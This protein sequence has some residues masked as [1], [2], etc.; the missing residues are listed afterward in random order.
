MDIEYSTLCKVIEVGGFDALAQARITDAFFMDEENLRVFQ[1]AHQH[2]DRHGVSPGHEAFDHEF[3]HLSLIETPEPLDYY[4]DELRDQRKYALVMGAIDEIKGP[5]SQNNADQAVKI[6]HAA[7]DGIHLE[8]NDLQDEDLTQTAGDSVDYYDRLGDN[9]GLKGWPTGFP[10]MDQATNGL[11]R[12]QLV[13]L[14]GLQKRYKSMVLMC[15][16]IACHKAGARTLFASFE[17]TNDEQR[18]RHHALRSG[19]SLTR[20]QRG[21]HTS[22]ERRLLVRM[23]HEVDGMQPFMLVHDP[24]ATSTVSSIAAKIRQHKPDIVFIDGSY[25]M[26][27]EVPNVQ[28]NSPQALTS[29][30]RALKRLAQRDEVAIVQTTQA[31]GWKARGGKL[32]LDSIGYSSS[33]AQDSDVIFGVEEIR[34]NGEVSDKEA[35]LRI[36]ASRN[37]PPRNVRLAIDLDRGA[38]LETDDVVYEPDDALDD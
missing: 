37:S 38:I 28:P 5:L 8:V 26:D 10:S 4:L 16:N 17:M 31:L 33:Y 35:T 18:T 30:T 32:S 9:P 1:W 36:L 13:T 29:I 20:L 14:V 34:E 25:L 7:L 3:P 27:S 15:M 23:T 6:L 11:Q 21:R 22:E 12:E 19:I 24:G 2:W